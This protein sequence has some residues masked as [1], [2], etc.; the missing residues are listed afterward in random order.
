MW[1]AL[2]LL[3]SGAILLVGVWRRTGRLLPTLDVIV[4]GFALGVV[5][6]RLGHVALHWSYFALHADEIARLGAGGLNWHGG[7]L[8]ALLGATLAAGVRRVPLTLV[9]DEAAVA[10]P[11]M[12]AAMW[13]ASAAANAAYGLEVRS[14]ADFP[15]WLVVESPD[16]YGVVAP[17]LALSVAGVGWAG[18]V[19]AVVALVTAAGGLAGRRFWLALAAYALGMAVIDVFRAD[20]VALIAGRRADHVLDLIVA[21]GA[22]VMLVLVTAM[23]GYRRR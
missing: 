8:G 1:I 5:G 14:L 23:R 18:V 10:V 2:G 6:A 20:E 13:L 21:A 9:L 11:I 4:A 7:L 17:R 19:L 22:T 16:V 3:I 12:G 15:A